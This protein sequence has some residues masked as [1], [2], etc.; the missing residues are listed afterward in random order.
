VGLALRLIKLDGLL[1]YDE[2][3][4]YAFA[5]RNPFWEMWNYALNDPTPPFYYS[6]LYFTLRLLEDQPAIMKVRSVLFGSFI[7]AMM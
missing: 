5:R 3:M 1:S 7:S 6:L 2:V 4:S